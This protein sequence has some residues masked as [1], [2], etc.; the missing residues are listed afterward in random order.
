MPRFHGESQ[1]RA[2]L[3]G[4]ATPTSAALS[5]PVRGKRT[6]TRVKKAATAH[7]VWGELAAQSARKI[8]TFLSFR[9]RTLRDG[10]APDREMVSHYM[11]SLVRRV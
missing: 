9:E 8:H 10:L 6:A 7:E 4:R 1:T 3:K 5:G 2:Q 11:F